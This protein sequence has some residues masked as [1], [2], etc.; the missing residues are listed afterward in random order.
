MNKYKLKD[1]CT[2]IYSGGTP[3][4]KEPKYWGGNIPWLSSSE[5]GKDFIY[6]TDNY[7]S[8]LALKETSTKYVSKNTVIIATAGEGKTRGQVSYLKIG[9][10]I[11]Q[12]LI[13]LETDAKKV[14]SL[15]LYYYL[16]NS[17]SRIR[18]LSNATGIRG[19]LSGARL[20]EL[21][22]FIP[23][24][25]EQLKISDLLYKLDLKIQNNKKQIEIL[26]TL[27][28]TIYD[29]WFV[30][31]DF[32]NE[33]GKPYK[34]SG[35]KMVWNEELKREIP[36]GWRCIKLCNIFSFIKGKIPQKLLEQKEPSLEQYITIDV[37]NGGTPLYCLPALMPYCNS[38][39]IM[40]MDGAASGDVYVGI[41]GVLGSTFS[42]LKS[43][44]EDIS[45]SYIYLILNSLKKIYKKAN[46]GSTVPH[47]N[48]KYIENMVIALPND[49]KF[50][51]RKFD[52]IYA[53]IKLQKLL[54]KNLNSLKSFLLPLL[55]N[56]QVIIK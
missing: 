16:K 14:D 32:P 55:M 18:S 19:S 5:S 56:G 13:A 9:A 53:Q 49:C 3:S 22:V 29:Y 42:M 39:T 36:E 24:V 34:S 52:E 23:D 31:F 54:I 25:S 30:Q 17:Y 40:V 12:S 51:S 11:N 45:N 38:E 20:K 7:I 21:I 46:T 37:A 15:F 48:R 8:N 4:T 10:C 1:I 28:K 26:E 35:G 43:K 44:R 50:L 2:K 6:E 47:A 41:D 33:E 27:A